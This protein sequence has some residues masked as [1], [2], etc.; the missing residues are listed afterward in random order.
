MKLDTQEL[1][2][3]SEGIFQQVDEKITPPNSVCFSVNFVFDKTIGRAV[4]RDGTTILGAQMQAGK[5][6][7]GLF[8]HV[9]ST[10]TRQLLAL[11]NNAGDTNAKLWYLLNGTTWT[12]TTK[13]LTASLR[14]RFLS[15][16]DNVCIINGTDKVSSNVASTTWVTTGGPFDL[17][18]MPTGLYINEFKD[19]VYIAG[20]TT[21]PD[22]LYYSSIQTAGAVSWTSG[23]GFIDIEP[24]DGGGG[25]SGLAKVPGYLLVF[26]RRTLK[27]YDGQSTYPESLMNLGTPNQECIVQGRQSVFFF[28]KR[29]IF[30]TT[31][32]Y[33]RKVSRRIQDIIDAIPSSYYAKVS[34]WTD[35]D[36]IYFSI[37]D[38]TV[39]DEPVN[40]AVIAYS[41]DSQNWALFSF[42]NEFRLWADWIDSTDAEFI[43][44]GDEDGK[45]HKVLNGVSDNGTDIN[46]LL[47]YQKQEFGSRGLYKT[48]SKFVV[49][50]DKIRSGALSVRI[51][52]KGKFEPSGA[53]KSEFSCLEK[54]L[55]GR[56]FDIRIKGQ[57]RAGSIIGIDIP[58]IDIGASYAQ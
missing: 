38:I 11:F 46:Y 57:S 3:V 10:Q 43:V 51:D 27:R 40:N 36:K 16:M 4:L 6:I 8:C 37:G 31:G 13:T 39:Y 47:Q 54:S 7:L 5:T 48:I 52:G 30:E 34:G 12:D 14:A 24:E 19:R 15:Y 29:G 42:A 2:D 28:N 50:T 26:K 56:T 45:V 22:R 18:N 20:N 9:R 17:G 49:Y 44:A 25:I 41:L 32:G 21:E 33:P 23:N 1:R 53:I 55:S 58:G 35:G